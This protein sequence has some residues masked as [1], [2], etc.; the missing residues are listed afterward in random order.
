MKILQ[1]AILLF[2]H[3]VYANSL[4]LENKGDGTWNVNYSSDRDIRNFLF[5]VVGTTINNVSDGATDSARFWVD[6]MGSDVIGFSITGNFIPVGRGVLVVIEL[7]SV[8][9]GLSNIYITDPEGNIRTYA[10]SSE[11]LLHLQ[12]ED[13]E[14]NIN[15]QIGDVDSTRNKLMNVENSQN[16]NQWALD[17]IHSIRLDETERKDSEY[18]NRIPSANWIKSTITTCAKIKNDLARLEC[19]LESLN[20]DETQHLK[21][22]PAQTTS[23]GWTGKGL[24]Y[25]ENGQIKEDGNFKDG[26]KVKKWITYYENGAIQNK[27][28][29]K[30]GKRYGKWTFYHSE[31]KLLGFTGSQHRQIEREE[32]YTDGKLDGKMISYYKNGQIKNKANYKDGLSDGKWTFYYENGQIKEEGIFKDGNKIGKWTTYHENG[33]IKEEESHKSVEEGGK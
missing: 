3:F 9:S 7:S 24:T 10:D 4:S 11:N 26:N 31:G 33:Q 8:P 13:L 20:M 32:K 19:F 2:V 23:T 15:K 30:Y 12:Q 25:Y 6:A 27:G 17:S 1:I 22:R 14:D 16:L 18:A 21:D 5:S 29:Y 28:N